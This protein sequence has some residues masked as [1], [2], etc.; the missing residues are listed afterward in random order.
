MSLAMVPAGTPDP[1]KP[2]CAKQDRTAGRTGSFGM[3]AGRTGS[4]EMT[5]G[6]KGSF[7]MCGAGQMLS[8]DPSC[9]VSFLLATKAVGERSECLR[10]A[11]KS[12]SV[13]SWGPAGLRDDRH[14]KIILGGLSS[15]ERED[16]PHGTS[17]AP[18]K[19]F[20]MAISDRWFL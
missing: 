9:W 15:L 11:H 14:I 7:G 13:S 4:F 8:E 12:L 16:S 17:F 10:P 1:T 5:A 3:S 18:S 19:I 20:F 6:R 2:S